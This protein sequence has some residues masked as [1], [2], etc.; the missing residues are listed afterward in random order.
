MH[1]SLSLSLSCPSS[2]PHLTGKNRR[3]SSPFAGYGTPRLAPCSKIPRHAREDVRRP[4]DVARDRNSAY[5]HANVRQAHRERTCRAPGGVAVSPSAS[6]VSCHCQLSCRAPGGV[7]GKPYASRTSIGSVVRPHSSYTKPIQRVC[8]SA[9]TT[10]LIVVSALE[11][12]PARAPTRAGSDIERRGFNPRPR[13][14][15][16]FRRSLAGRVA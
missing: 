5:T 10:T 11:E 3:F 14:S 2:P 4:S 1:L 15:A 12:A 8:S 7:A 13:R 6:R 16:S 9:A